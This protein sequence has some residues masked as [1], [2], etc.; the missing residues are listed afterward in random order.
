MGAQSTRGKA[1]GEADRWAE[2]GN[3]EWRQHGGR[4]G[5]GRWSVS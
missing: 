1:C 3:S 4:G 2:M 5:E